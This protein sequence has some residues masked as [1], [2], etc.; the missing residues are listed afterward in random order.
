VFLSIYS[1]VAIAITNAAFTPPP[2][3]DAIVA[4]YLL[5]L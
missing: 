2:P 5:E 1:T 4:Y 3:E